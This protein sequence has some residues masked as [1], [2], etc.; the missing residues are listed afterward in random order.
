MNKT[1]P[2]SLL[3][4]ITYVTGKTLYI[5]VYYQVTPVSGLTDPENT[6]D[7]SL[8]FILEF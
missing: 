4:F 6:R 1:G 2:L 3:I 7:K 8:E 5:P